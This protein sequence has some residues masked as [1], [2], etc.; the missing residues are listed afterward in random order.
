MAVFDAYVGMRMWGVGT[1]YGTVTWAGYDAIVIQV[2]SH[3]Y[4]YYGNFSYDS[5]G[6]VYGTLT[7]Y[8]EYYGNTLLGEA[9]NFSVDAATAFDAINA[10]NADGLIAYIARG[11]DIVYGSDYADNIAGFG[12]NDALIGYAGNDLIYGGAGNDS[13][14]GGAGN[15]RMYG[16]SGNDEFYILDGSD[17]VTEYANEGTD[18]AQISVNYTLTA[19][20]ENLAMNGSGN[21]SGTGNGL[22]NAMIGN[23]GNN[24][25]NGLSGN[26]NINGGSGN[27]VLLGGIGNDILNGAAG[28]DRLIGGAGADR[29]AGGAG[30]DTFVFTVRTE[31]TV[32]SGGRDI[33][34]DFSRSQHDRIDLSAIDANTNRTGEQA[35]T[36]IGNAGFTGQAGQVSAR[37][38]SG[39]TL[40]SGDVNGDRVADFSILLDDRM[41]LSAS[42]FIL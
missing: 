15:D 33:I 31:S 29:M 18:R 10:G 37:A 36:Y 4:E 9:Y 6:N 12:G 41:T 23:T 13:I 30:V 32:A 42:D 40:I 26:D 8:A 35:F 27:D 11:S 21:L 1:S 39:G 34:T 28:A 7:G 3:T 17:N 19:N 2:G 20:V 25:L 5:Y 22:A 24:R 38:V 16:G 14:S